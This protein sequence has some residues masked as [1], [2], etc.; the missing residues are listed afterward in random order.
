MDVLVP[1][2]IALVGV[3]IG[4]TV[5]R[6][7]NQRVERR[8]VYS[9]FVDALQRRWSAQNILDRNATVNARPPVQALESYDAAQK[10]LESAAASI[11]L[12][13]PPRTRRA[14][15]RLISARDPDLQE[16]KAFRNDVL[17]QFR[18]DLSYD[19]RKYVTGGRPRIAA[20]DAKKGMGSA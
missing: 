9:K 6:N 8:E 18:Y 16:R 14:V 1:S 2:F 4:L 7:W 5:N 13:A 10:D 12:I 11:D 3:L 17:A 19:V 15:R 20:P